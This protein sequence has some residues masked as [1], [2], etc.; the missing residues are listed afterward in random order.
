MNI[1]RLVFQDTDTREYYQRWFTN[2]EQAEDEGERIVSE[3]LA[4]WSAVDKVRVGPPKS[5]YLARGDL[6]EFLNTFALV[7]TD[8]PTRH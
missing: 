7:S 4:W 6:V 5:S 3:K 1:W 8:E 2:R